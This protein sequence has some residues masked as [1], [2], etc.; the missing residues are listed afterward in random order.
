M[1]DEVHKVFRG[2]I[3]EIMV[4]ADQALYRPFVLYE[5][6]KPVLYVWL[7]KA[8]YCCLKSALLFYKNLVGNLEAYGFRINPYDPCVDKKMIG[9]KHLTVCWHVDNLK[10]SCVETNEV[11]N[12]IQWIKS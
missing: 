5:T 6:V 4:V 7:H 2:T 12:M 11:T 3:A 8:L 1:D 10:I 9:G